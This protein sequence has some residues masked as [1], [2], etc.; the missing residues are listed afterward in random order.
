MFMQ[1]MVTLLSM[2]VLW[3]ALGDHYYSYGTAFVSRGNRPLV[4]GDQMTDV[5]IVLIDWAG[6]TYWS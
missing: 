5:L 4:I 1:T 2:Y 6:V 3:P